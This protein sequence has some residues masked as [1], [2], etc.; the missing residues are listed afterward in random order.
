MQSKKLGGGK[1]RV[2]TQH[3]LE[4]AEIKEDAVVLKDGTMRAVLVVASTN[5]ALKSEEEQNAVIGGYMQ[6]LNSLEHPLQIV[7]QSRRLNIDEYLARLERSEKEQTN[8]L[9]KAQISD[10]RSFVKELVELGE[11]M[12][13]RF[14]II[15]PYSPLSDKR[16]GFW[17]RLFELVQPSMIIHLKEERFRV[18]RA[19]LMQHV[20]HI[21]TGLSSLGLN[22]VLLDTQGLIELYYRVY[23]PDIF[24]TEKLTDVGKIRTEESL[25]V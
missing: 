10:Y 6:F 17:S 23:N 7:V 1:V 25:S 19:A 2:S 16:K 9:L 15:V 11:I 13:K 12:S 18:H 8:E 20:N 14:F 22:S 24:E 5:F 4:I 3:Y 21:M